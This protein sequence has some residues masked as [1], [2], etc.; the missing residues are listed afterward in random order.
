MFMHIFKCIAVVLLL[1]TFDSLKLSVVFDVIEQN[2]SLRNHLLF[3][4]RC[5]FSVV[6]VYGNHNLLVNYL[7][8]AFW[9]WPTFFSH[10]STH[11]THLVLAATEI[12]VSVTWSISKAKNSCCFL[13]PSNQ[14]FSIARFGSLAAVCGS[15]GVLEQ[16]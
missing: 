11:Y 1:Q 10:I 8:R 3:I 2:T 14:I 7:C 4:S 6:I 16:T 13:L 5:I 9:L 12:T 15:I